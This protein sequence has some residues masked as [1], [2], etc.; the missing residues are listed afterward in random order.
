MLQVIVEELSKGLF[1]V[2][3]TITE[4]HQSVGVC[5]VPVGEKLGNPLFDVGTV[6][7]VICFKLGPKWAHWT[8]QQ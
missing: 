2:N 3:E 1:H 7:D 6:D 8:C 5:D 4:G